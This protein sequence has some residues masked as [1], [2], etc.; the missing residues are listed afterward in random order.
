[1]SFTKRQLVESA[2]GELALASYTFDLSPDEIQ[3]GLLRIE[4]MLRSW[5]NLGIDTGYVFP[6]T[7]AKSNPDDPSGMLDRYEEAVR[8][9]GSMRIAP[10][11]GK[12]VSQ[13][14]RTSAAIAYQSML[15]GRPVPVVQL[16]GNLPVGAGNRAWGWG[17]RYFAPCLPATVKDPS[18]LSGCDCAD[19][20]VTP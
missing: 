4:S 6:V 10:L 5:L 14:T 1:M 18:V 16:P 3:A 15:V 9:N 7:P 2:Y 13:E 8:T 11:F 20:E 19:D 12:T 17:P